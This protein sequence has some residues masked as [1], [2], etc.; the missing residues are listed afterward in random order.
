M[1]LSIA[2]ESL[3]GVGTLR[4]S[5]SG[6]SSS[7]PLLFGWS[8]PHALAVNSGSLVFFI[9][10]SGGIKPP[11]YRQWGSFFW[12]VGS[13]HIR[14]VDRH[15]HSSWHGG[16]YPFHSPP[17]YCVWPCLPW[18]SCMSGCIPHGVWYNLITRMY[19]ITV[20]ILYRYMKC[21]K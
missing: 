11:L 12:W 4:W 8:H 7:Y 21:A 18:P 16:I 1:I 2:V 9:F 13:F 14:E 5:R 3:E 17:F 15:C 20:P 10:F 6:G 19:Y